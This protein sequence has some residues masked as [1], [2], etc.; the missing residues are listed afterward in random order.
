MKHDHG[1]RP[2]M[3]KLLRGIRSVQQ[4]DWGVV[5]SVAIVGGRARGMG[6]R[7]WE[8]AG[9]QARAAMFRHLEGHAAVHSVTAG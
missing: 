3:V 7:Q 1:A 6:S 9:G 8:R 4:G 2:T 5:I